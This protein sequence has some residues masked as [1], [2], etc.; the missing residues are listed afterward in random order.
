MASKSEE[1]IRAAMGK[2]WGFLDLL[3][4]TNPEEYKR[5][6]DKA[7][8]E[9][10]E[11][12]DPPQPVFCFSTGIRGVGDCVLKLGVPHPCHLYIY[13]SLSMPPSLPPSFPPPLFPSLYW[14][15]GCG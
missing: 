8:E 11:Y 4:E 9:R 6:I 1:E 3:A 5:F 14:N 13:G 2:M 7:M 12:L 10:K 15:K